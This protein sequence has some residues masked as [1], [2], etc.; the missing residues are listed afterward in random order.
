MKNNLEVRCLFYKNEKYGLSLL[1][2]YNI[3]TTTPNKINKI[4]TPITY[5]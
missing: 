3:S 1:I 5:S 4:C 2:I